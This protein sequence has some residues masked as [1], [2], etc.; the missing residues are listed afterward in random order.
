VQITKNISSKNFN[1]SKHIKK[2]NVMQQLH[3]FCY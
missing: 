1:F 2:R 3:F